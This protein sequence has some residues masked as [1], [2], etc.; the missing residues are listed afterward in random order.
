LPNFKA[1]GTVACDKAARL[2]F[3]GIISQSEEH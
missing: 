3:A 2:K 1:V